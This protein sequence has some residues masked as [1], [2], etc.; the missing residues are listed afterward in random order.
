MLDEKKMSEHVTALYARLAETRSRY[1]RD[2]LNAEEGLSRKEEGM[3]LL[4]AAANF[5]RVTIVSEVDPAMRHNAVQSFFDILVRNLNDASVE[6]GE[7]KR[8]EVRHEDRSIQ[9]VLDEAAKARE[10]QARIIIQ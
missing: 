7:I 1:F 9:D 2:M 8:E 6:P 4:Q 10:E 5:F 3:I